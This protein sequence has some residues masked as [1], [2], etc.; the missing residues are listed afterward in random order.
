MQF[1]YLESDVSIVFLAKLTSR[2]IAQILIHKRLN[3]KILQVIIIFLPKKN[4]ANF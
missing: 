1:L 2:K 4:I 3:F